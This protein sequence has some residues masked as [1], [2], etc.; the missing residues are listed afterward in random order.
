MRFLILGCNGM[1]G[2]TISQYMKHQGHDVLGFDRNL[3]PFVRSVA[4]D[5]TDTQTLGTIIESEQFD[6]IINCIGILNQFADERK[7]LAVF[8]NSYLPHFLAE[9]TAKMDT[10][11]IHMST[12]C[13]FSGKRGGYTEQDLRDGTT[14]Y[15]RTK[16]LGE[17]EDNKNL[18]L[19][20]SIIGPDINAKGIGLFN[21]FMK[22]DGPINGYSKAMWTGQTTLQLAKTMEQ[23]AKERVSGL[24]NAVPD[25]SISKYDLLRLFNKYFR[26]G[27]IQINPNN[28]F[29]AD[30]SLKRTRFEFS[31]RIPDYE[32]MVY[33][34][35]EWV[36]A[37]RD[38]YPHYHL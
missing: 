15:D 4:G 37:N 14:F 20:N 31:Y 26:A 32:Q 22:Q 21:W 19:R 34:L 33:E 7:P 23:A 17:L 28:D 16:A 25:D 3:S 9:A 13:V 30:K 1:A 8:L 29:V 38:L 18:T 10:Q 2:H 27:S 35:Y 36:V 12:D 5:A 6:A 11:V 24:I